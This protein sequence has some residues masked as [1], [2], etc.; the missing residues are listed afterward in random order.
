VRNDVLRRD[1]AVS[2]VAMRLCLALALVCASVARAD[3]IQPRFDEDDDVRVRDIIDRVL[4]HYGYRRDATPENCCGHVDVDGGSGVVIIVEPLD[5]SVRRDIAKRGPMGNADVLWWDEESERRI[6]RAFPMGRI[7]LHNPI[8]DAQDF[9]IW[10]GKR[11]VRRVTVGAHAD[12]EVRDLPEG[13]LRVRRVGSVLD[14]WI[15]VTPWPSRVLRNQGRR[16]SFAVPFGRYKLRGWHPSGGE[17]AV[18]VTASK[19]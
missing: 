19:S 7:L 8:G 16:E 9:E 4:A 15:Y 10:R 14:G 13:I 17:R 18:I 12:L 11:L 1:V 5:G 6:A 3:Q 2:V